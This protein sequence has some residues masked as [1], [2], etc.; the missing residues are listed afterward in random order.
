MC[1]IVLVGLRARHMM[2]LGKQSNDAIPY[3]SG[4]AAPARATLPPTT[5]RHFHERRVRH[6]SGER[7]GTSQCTAQ[8]IKPTNYKKKKDGKKK[9]KQQDAESS[10]ETSLSNGITKGVETGY[11]SKPRSKCTPSGTRQ[12]TCVREHTARFGW[13]NEK[14]WK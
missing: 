5:T 1:D 6:R 10:V 4:S 8:C 11:G 2:L 7:G 9:Q 13:R 12:Q 14:A 3:I